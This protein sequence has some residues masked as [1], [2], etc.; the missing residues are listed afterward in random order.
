VVK[1]RLLPS[2]LVLLGLAMV[3][4]RLGDARMRPEPARIV[5]RADQAL[6]PVSPMLFGQDY[7]P[8]MNTTE[9]FAADY[10]DA[11]VTLLRFPAGNWGDENDLFPNNLDDLAM[12]AALVLLRRWKGMSW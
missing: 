8:W 10:R 5:V 1:T 11:G 4:P 7:G 2:G 12:L 6:A 9:T 3:G